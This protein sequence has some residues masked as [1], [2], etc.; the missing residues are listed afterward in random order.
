MLARSREGSEGIHQ[1]NC[2][3]IIKIRSGGHLVSITYKVVFGDT[4]EVCDL[5]GLHAA[6]I[7]RIHLT[8]RM[9]NGRF[10]RKTL[11]FSKDIELGNNGNTI[12]QISR[13]SLFP[14]QI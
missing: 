7:E 14:S 3:Q 13:T 9:M 2:I 1:L 12:R 4:I 5:M 8:S 6:Y 10:V 11:S